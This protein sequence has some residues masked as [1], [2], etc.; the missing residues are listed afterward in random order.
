ML[1]GDAEL[2]NVTEQVGFALGVNREWAW[3]GSHG[4]AMHTPPPVPPHL[5]KSLDLRVVK[6]YGSKGYNK[7]RISVV[8]S[9]AVNDTNNGL[10][11][12]SHQF[13]HRWTQL[14]LRSGLLTVKPGQE[15]ALEIDGMTVRLRLPLEDA[16]VRGIVFADPCIGSPWLNCSLGVETFLTSTRLPAL[17]NAAAP[18]LDYWGTWGDNFYDKNGSL[19]TQFFA[20]LSLETKSRIMFAAAGNHDF[21]VSGSPQ[22]STPEDQFGNGYLQYYA[23]DS[24]AS[25]GDPS[26]P[27]NLSVSPD[28]AQPNTRGF[29]PDARN[30]VHY[31]KV[32][33][34][35]YLVFSGV[36]GFAELKPQFEEFCAWLGTEDVA[37]AFIAAHFNV[38]NAGCQAGMATSL[39]YKA[40]RAY[41]GCKE[42]DAKGLL[43]YQEGHE[44]CN[45]VVDPGVGIM[46]G[47][48]GVGLFGCNNSL[49]GYDN[50][51]IP[52]VDSTGGRVRVL[53]YPVADTRGV[54]N[55]DAIHD[56]FRDR[57][58]SACT[59]LA[60]VWID[61]PL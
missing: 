10:F 53:Y 21:W 32:G 14:F 30:F 1:N 28:G 46:V 8:T 42:L 23:L 49:W 7:L 41:P 51:G 31:S 57:G 12:Y 17:L 20:Q 26:Q 16:G 19:T 24:A 22:A 43:M 29:L 59:H 44:H 50:F 5:S 36:Y 55:Y 45:M 47:G 25:Q 56:C 15:T 52:V 2:A 13:R 34:Q 37:V 18:Q 11:T 54:D 27:F 60:E 39:V 33:N 40:I 58:L 6:A 38:V 3:G 48:Q 9:T 4:R 35:G 61:K